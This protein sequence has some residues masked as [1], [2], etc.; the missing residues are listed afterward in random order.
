V[1]ITEIE[2]ADEP[3]LRAYYSVDLAA[4]STDVPLIPM[5][6]FEELAAEQADLPSARRRRFIAWEGNR[7]V[8][9]ALV[10][11]PILD[12]T[13]AAELRL[14]VHPDQRRRGVGR[15]LLAVATE[16]MRAEGRTHAISESAEPLDG[17]ATAGAAFA[18]AV[19]ATRALEEICR[20]LAFDA[21][22]DAQLIALE[23]EATE[24]ADGYELVQWIGPCSDTVVDDLALLQGRMTTD[25][26]LGDLS[27][28]AEAWDRD[29][30]RESEA[31]SV[32]L[33]R[34]WVTT[35]ARHIDSGRVV[36]F[37]D[38][39]VSWDQMRDAGGVAFQWTTIVAPEHR[40]RR[41]GLML[42]AAN[43]RLLRQ[44]MPGIERVVT[45]N[46]ESNKHM[47]V[48]NET[49]GFRPHLRFCQW[50]LVVSP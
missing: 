38:I 6:P 15:A 27:W 5:P 44:E 33:G 23:T 20:V 29:R 2:Q 40:G 1:N 17:A 49:L 46:A 50:Q 32:R 12:N 24:Y 3:A 28:E 18:A 8:G 21:V 14:V 11:L 7:P 16:R 45:W 26:P 19:G 4:H 31:R 37:T 10:Y 34:R 42:K 13:D 39:G 35:A 25:V 36:G 43:L 9:I 30:V 48:I 47:I 41:L 22:D